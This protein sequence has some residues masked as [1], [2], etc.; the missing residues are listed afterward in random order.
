[1]TNLNLWELRTSASFRKNQMKTIYFLSI[2]LVFT[3]C[4]PKQPNIS[5]I[6]FKADACF[7]T[8]PIFTMT[9]L[10]DGTANYDARLYNERQGQFRTIVRKPQLDSLLAYIANADFFSLKENYSTPITDQPTYILTVKL[11]NGKSKTIED[12][13]PSG[14]KNLD[15]IY[16]LLFSLRETQNW[17]ITAHND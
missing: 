12:Y 16:A 10:N 3:S 8:C 11:K 7:G 9:I 5:Q 4:R 13:G 14:P 1:M 15:K 17:K 6:D 2:V